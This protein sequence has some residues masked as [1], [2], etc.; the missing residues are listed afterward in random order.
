MDIHYR[1]LFNHSWPP[2]SGYLDYFKDTYTSIMDEQSWQ[3]VA[4]YK[5][6]SGS[7]TNNN[8]PMATLSTTSE[9]MPLRRRGTS[10]DDHD[11]PSASPV[12]ALENRP[13]ENV[14]LLI[15][16]RKEPQLY[17]SLCDGEIQLLPKP[18]PSSGSFWYC[19]R[20][21]GWYGFRNTVSGTY[22]GYNPYSSICA[23]ERQ[24][25]SSEY[26]TAEKDVNGGYI[27][28]V[29]RPSDSH[30]M[31]VSVSKRNKLLFPQNEGGT[32]WDLFESKYLQ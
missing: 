2:E 27:L 25:S 4:D 19:V 16:T 30:L 8:T 23:I 1:E 5:S 22:L 20:M 21:G 14:P 29:F 7:E 26:L 24:Q 6:T 13:I 15:R 17:L 12:Q 9:T 18:S 32:A 28:N 31:P 11:T 10:Q 3:E